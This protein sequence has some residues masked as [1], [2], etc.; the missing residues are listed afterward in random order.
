MNE[1]RDIEASL[2]ARLKLQRVTFGACALVL[3]TLAV[4]GVAYYRDM[5]RALTEA[6]AA[7]LHADEEVAR[8]RMLVRQMEGDVAVA[9]G[10]TASIRRALALE[11]CRLAARELLLGHED[12]ARGLLSEAAALGPPAWAGL[13]SR[14]LPRPPAPFTGGSHADLPVLFGAAS[15]DRSRVGVVRRL[16]ESCLLE[17]YAVESGRLLFSTELP[18]ADE[19]ELFLDE[20]GDNAVVRAGASLLGGPAEGPL[21]R[22]AA[23]AGAVRMAAVSPDGRRVVAA[24]GRELRLD[25]E[26]LP[27]PEGG[28]LRALALLPGAALPVA[29]VVEGTVHVRDGE[30]WRVVHRF[31]E[32]RGPAALFSRG[33]ALLAAEVAG[34]GVELATI[35]LD[36][37]EPTVAMHVLSP[38]A[39]AEARF[40]SDG[41]LHCMAADRAMAVMRGGDVQEWAPGAERVAFAALAANGLVYGDRRGQ[42]ATLPRPAEHYLGSSLL[43]VPS[44]FGARAHAGGFTLV[45]PGGNSAAWAAGE[46]HTAGPLADVLPAEGGFA[47]MSGDAILLPWGE[48]VSSEREGLLLAAW[49]SGSVLLWKAPDE[50]VFLSSVSRDSQRTPP[51]A[52]DD[53]AI[54][55]N[56]YAAALRFGEDV[57]V[58]YR[59]GRHR[60][61]TAAFEQ[62]PELI[63]L[64]ADGGTLAASMG[65]VVQVMDRDGSRFSFRT[66]AAPARLALL[67]SGSVLA[68]LEDGDVAYY[69]TA[70]GRLLARDAAK[71]TDLSAAGDAELNIVAGGFLR[72]LAIPAGR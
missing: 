51:S 40:L 9:R 59:E 20:R 34:R 5:Q 15:G 12:R 25:G 39:W 44:G 1:Q 68:T 71:A 32:G 47:A 69:E 61:W 45:S 35:P 3:A 65:S 64:A 29:V 37:G 6:E 62:A 58:L 38:L 2:L 22:L 60:P 67:F 8:Q 23:D 27:L 13:I 63:A 72:V 24:T 19:G 66:S 4:L 28:E 18:V 26:A 16:R 42:L 30:E 50:T 33:G 52:P 17:I 14:R 56:A 43:A 48:R 11:K 21:A 49:P 70:T 36:D 57:R 10:E 31:A 7:T 46:W 55:A 53:A 54:A 41:S